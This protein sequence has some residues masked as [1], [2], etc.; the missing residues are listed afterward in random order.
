MKEFWNAVNNIGD[1][2]AEIKESKMHVCWM[3]L[4]PELVQDFKGFDETPEDA[5]KKLFML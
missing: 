4:F 2:W 5:T 1:S 3:R